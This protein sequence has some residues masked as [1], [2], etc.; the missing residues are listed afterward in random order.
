MKLLSV[1]EAARILSVSPALVRRY[2]QRGRLPAT[3]VGGA[4]WV[5]DEA[6]LA[7]FAARP[8][9]VGNKSGKPR[10]GKSRK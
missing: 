1:T 7:A 2:C 4:G 3:K 5:I 6:A 9:P 10:T 8:R